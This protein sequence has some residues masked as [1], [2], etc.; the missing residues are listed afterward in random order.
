MN[1]SFLKASV[2]LCSAVMLF[3][4]SENKG[5][6]VGPPITGGSIKL[7][8]YLMSVDGRKSVRPF[9][10]SATKPWKVELTDEQKAWIEVIPSEGEG[11]YKPTSI[12]VT[13]KENAESKLPRES[14][15]TFSLVNPTEENSNAVLKI[16]QGTEYFMKKDS[17]AVLEL[18]KATDG[19]NWT[20]GWDLSQPISK[21]GFYGQGGLA[22]ETNYWNGVYVTKDATG[23]RRIDRLAW[24]EPV[25][26]KGKLPEQMKELTAMRMFEICGFDLQGQTFTEFMDVLYNWKSLQI[27]WMTGNCKMGGALIPTKLADFRELFGI[28][29][30][31]HDFIGFEEDFGSVNF[32]E[33]VGFVVCK[34][35]LEGELKPEYFDKMPKVAAIAVSDNNLS[36]TVSSKLIMGKPYLRLMELNGNR[37]TGDFPANIRNSPIWTNMDSPDDPAESYFCPQQPGAGFNAGTCQ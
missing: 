31:G 14:S 20:K 11:S 35:T 18:Y 2:I 26:M 27:F 16:T 34:G 36:G 24:F 29:F 13:L 25:G 30:T 28:N 23:S 10:L 15:L 9:N 19:P 6:M 1:L 5:D 17:L 37:F 21:W 33:L 3:A 12:S 22:V 32:P 7:N 4:C 8:N